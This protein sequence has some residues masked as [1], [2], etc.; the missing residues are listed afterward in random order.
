MSIQ[1]ES[2]GLH[3]ENGSKARDLPLVLKTLPKGVDIFNGWNSGISSIDSGNSERFESDF[4]SKILDY[5]WNVKKICVQDDIAVVSYPEYTDLNKTVIQHVNGGLYAP[6]RKFNAANYGEEDTAYRPI[7]NNEL[8][9]PLLNADNSMAFYRYG[10]QFVPKLGP[11][12]DFSNM[13]IIIEYD[14]YYSDSDGV[15]KYNAS[16]DGK[17]ELFDE[18]TF[19]FDPYVRYIK[20]T[21]QKDAEIKGFYRDDILTNPRTTNNHVSNVDLGRVDT[22]RN[23]LLGSPYQNSNSTI[24]FGFLGYRKATIIKY[25]PVIKCGKVDLYKRKS[26][27]ITSISN[28]SI[29]V[30]NNHKLQNGDMIK[31]INAIRNNEADQN[32]NKVKYVQV[33]NNNSFI[34]YE[35]D[36]FNR[37]TP[38][39]ASGLNADWICIGN[40]Y[41]NLPDGWEYQK[42][43]FSP[44][45]RNGYVLNNFDTDLNDDYIFETYSNDNYVI[46]NVKDIIE[47]NSYKDL[48]MAD[49]F[50]NGINDR[51]DPLVVQKIKPRSTSSSLDLLHLGAN[52]TVNSCRFGSD[53]DFKKINGKYYLLV[54]ERGPDYVF[55]QTYTVPVF[56]VLNLM[57]DPIIYPTNAPYGKCHLIEVSKDVNNN[58]NCT[59]IKTISAYHND[60]QIS[61]PYS[62]GSDVALDNFYEHM[63]QYN[64]LYQTTY[65]NNNYWNRCYV[66]RN[67][68]GLA[69]TKNDYWYGSY[70]YSLDISKVKTVLDESQALHM[71]GDFPYCCIYFS[72][73]GLPVY[74]YESNMDASNNANAFSPSNDIYCFNDGFG[75]S[76]GL[77][78]HNGNF[79]IAASSKTKTRVLPE[80]LINYNN[81][82]DYDGV[83]EIPVNSTDSNRVRHDW[84]PLPYDEQYSQF[85]C[86]YVHVYTYNLTSDALVKKGKISHIYE[87]LS[88]N[89][90]SLYSKAENYAKTIKIINDRIFFGSSRAMEYYDERKQRLNG[91]PVFNSSSFEYS[92]DPS[93]IYCYDYNTLTE[94]YKIENKNNIQHSYFVRNVGLSVDQTANYKTDLLNGDISKNWRLYRYVY[95]RVYVPYVTPVDIKIFP[96]DRFGDSFDI[97]NDMLITNCFDIYNELGVKHS[98]LNYT[99]DDPRLVS[100]YIHIYQNK[101]GSWSYVSKISPTI[102]SISNNITCNQKL[103]SLGNFNYSDSNFNSLTWDLDLSGAYSIADDRIVLKDPI[104]YSVFRRIMANEQESTMSGEEI[105]ESSPYFKYDEFFI[106]Y[107]NRGAFDQNCNFYHIKYGSLYRYQPNSTVSD[108]YSQDSWDLFY[109]TPI[110]MYSI[111]ELAFNRVYTKGVLTIETEVIEDSGKDFYIKLYKKDPRLNVDADYKNNFEYTC[112]QDGSSFLYSNTDPSGENIYSNGALSEIDSVLIKYSSFTENGTTR[113]YTFEIPSNLLQQYILS[114][115]QLQTSVVVSNSESMSL[116][117]DSQIT[118]NSSVSIFNTLLLGLCFGNRSYSIPNSGD[119]QILSVKEMQLKLHSNSLINS[120][121]NAREFSC[122]YNKVLSYSNDVLNSYCGTENILN[123]VLGTGPSDVNSSAVNSFKSYQVFSVTDY[124]LEDFSVSDI[125]GSYLS[126]GESLDIEDLTYLPLF[127]SSNFYK[128]DNISMYTMGSF[129]ES[130]ATNLVINGAI[131]T[132]GE[133]NLFLG[134]TTY[135]SNVN[136]YVEALDDSSASGDSSK[137]LNLV[138]YNGA[139]VIGTLQ[140]SNFNLSIKT[141]DIDNILNIYISGPMIESRNINLNILGHTRFVISNCDAP[142]LY[143]YGSFKEIKDINLSMFA[144]K[145]ENIT[146]FINGPEVLSLDTSLFIESKIQGIDNSANLTI[147]NSTGFFPLYL[148]TPTISE[149]Y[150]TLFIKYDPIT[151]DSLNDGSINYCGASANTIPFDISETTSESLINKTNSIVDKNYTQDSNVFGFK[152]PDI[153]L[154]SI[155]TD[156]DFY[157]H[158]RTTTLFDWN[159]SNLVV[160]IIESGRP[161]ILVF[162]FLNNQAIFERKIDL[163]Q[164]YFNQNLTAGDCLIQ[165]IKISQSGDIAISVY[166]ERKNTQNNVHSGK[167]DIT[168]LNTDGTIINSFERSFTGFSRSSYLNNNMGLSLLFNG[169]TLIYSYEDG[170]DS[171]IYTRTK[172]QNYQD[173]VEKLS[174]FGMLSQLYGV[175]PESNIFSGRVPYNKSAFGHKI[176]MSGD[177]TTIAISAPLYNDF[178]SSDSTNNYLDTYFHGICFY[179]NSNLVFSG[180]VNKPTFSISC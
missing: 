78:Y 155:K 69:Y 173:P 151:V 72:N 172:T 62:M 66:I 57:P 63:F 105:I 120:V 80:A 85:D 19:S 143:T 128:D 15:I 92:G 91:G 16:L 71:N 42:T 123:P 43:L 159:S 132:S 25:T 8:F 133:V 124:N 93:A 161:K 58:L 144:N 38:T 162:S 40:I 75:K 165:D 167:F 56:P 94:L 83:V 126:I 149:S 67:L 26:G 96:S 36:Q 35:D 30:S 131:P 22:I 90:D 12:L 52:S 48:L 138:F 55:Q 119:N 156:Y 89:V 114:G 87:S 175:V 134:P 122:V 158:G 99:Y 147:V 84:I 115:D 37:R 116:D 50:Y 54:G 9:L 61:K 113:I 76:V 148:S 102:D 166:L 180:S 18:L 5:K 4:S 139:R 145:P 101:K 170:Y 74:S 49:I 3:I 164:G 33:V 11:A 41:N 65:Q 64:E 104:S 110:F 82:F 174:F 129:S 98:D 125:S 10:N 51:T 77:S 152:D 24:V 103:R 117:D 135:S 21:T 68:F 2:I 97:S 29:C 127:L 141:A 27:V 112:T 88:G 14:G 157:R 171:K 176:S 107:L 45:G 137:N 17:V 118:Y 47:S 142:T 108:T 100:D 154:R 59:N 140:E 28:N 31:I 169:D 163:Y 46:P 179:V 20:L 73:Y 111:P 121:Y 168:V 13:F 70:L 160:G 6:A 1:K 136:L 153:S 95:G 7:F 39:L 130:L 177:G 86:G 53:I 81:S 146:L 34:I 32:L 150:S 23:D 106:S 178:L 109:E 60:S 79:I 44:T